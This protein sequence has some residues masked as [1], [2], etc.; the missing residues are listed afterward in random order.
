MHLKGY[1]WVTV[2]KT[3]GEDGDAEYWATSHVD[4]TAAQRAE[5]ADIAWKIETYHRGL[6][7]Y[8]GIEKSQHR[9]AQS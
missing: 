9:K 6:K 2:F 4:V 7:Q 8:T 1:G 3:V 5:N